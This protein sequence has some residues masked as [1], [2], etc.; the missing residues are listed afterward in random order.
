LGCCVCGR[1]IGGSFI[2]KVARN[3]API[4]LERDPDQGV[5]ALGT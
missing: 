5:V 2:R 1:G 3:L 4:L